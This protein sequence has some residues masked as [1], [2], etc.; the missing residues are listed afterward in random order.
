V[1]NVYFIDCV[2]LSSVFCL[3]VFCYFV[4]YVYLYGVFY[5]STTA[6]GNN[7]FPGQLNNNNNNNNMLGNDCPSDFWLLKNGSAPLH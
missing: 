7:P 6:T 5:C 2:A 1:C 4:C 3:S